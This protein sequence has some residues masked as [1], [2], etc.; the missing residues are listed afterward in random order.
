MKPTVTALTAVLTF[1]LLPTVSYAQDQPWLK[2]RRYREGAGIRAG[3][4][5]LHP[6]LAAEFG[7]DS[8]YFRRADDPDEDPIGSLRLRITPSFSLSTLGPQ[9]REG[10]PPPTL[11][12][13]AGIAATYNEF[14]PVSGSDAGQDLMSDQRNIGGTLDL[15]LDILPQR[16]W[17]GSVFGHLGRSIQ[18]SNEGDTTISF[19]RLG[20]RTGAEAGWAPGAGLLD[21]RLGYAFNGTIFESDRF[22]QLTNVGHE[23]STRGRWRFLPRSGIL[24]DGRINFVSYP[25][26]DEKT[27]SHPLR[28]RLG[29]NGLITNSFAVLAMA[30]WGASFYE[31][32]PGQA[33][34]TV[35]DFDSVIG[36]AELKWYLTPNPTDDPQ[37]AGLSLS[38]LSVGF[39][40]DFFDSYIGTYYE[41]DRGYA[42]FS[43][44]FAG[45]FLVALEGGVAAIVYPDV[46]S[47]PE[48]AW[49]DIRIDSSLL[50]EYRFADSFAINS[51]LR[52]NTNISDTSIDSTD[53]AGNVVSDSLQYQEFEAY[54]GARWFM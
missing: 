1:A 29:Y 25:D 45:A 16:E 20:F 54:L 8:N 26:G 31:P 18:P 28:A 4:F 14:F 42:N 34:D 6:G 11:E 48:P 38:T 37:G 50:A 23:I 49:T 7:Y 35:Q 2:D 15:R 46:V 17:F 44:F 52:Y 47:P 53:V 39:S 13:R 43:Y 3:D 12:F 24:Y 10:G 27:S 40:R 32:A 51:T 21:W 5:E 36:Q 30:G 41:R 22:T 9:R 19:N 33:E